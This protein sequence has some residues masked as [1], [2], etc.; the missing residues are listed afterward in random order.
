MD[1]FLLFSVLFVG[2]FFVGYVGLKWDFVIRSKCL[3]VRR[4]REAGESVS[5]FLEVGSCFMGRGERCRLIFVFCLGY[6]INE[7][8]F[9]G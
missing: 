8:L 9:R 3:V 5:V 2:V 7:D 4:L 1:Y 6:F